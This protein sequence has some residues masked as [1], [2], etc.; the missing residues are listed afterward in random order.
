MSTNGPVSVQGCA[1][2]IGRLAADGSVV[3]SAVGMVQDDRS[4]VKLEAKP[5]MQ[6][7]VEI[8]PISGCGVPV[9]SYKDC[10][11]YKRWDINLTIGDMDFEKMEILG[12][13]AILTAAGSTGRTF[14]DG[15]VTTNLNTLSSPA[16]AAFLPSD[17]GRSVTGT[18]IPS[19]TFISQYVS[20]TLVRI[21]NLATATGAGL[22]IVLGAQPVSTIGYQ[23]PHLLL[24]ACPFGVSIEVWSKAIVRGTGY[25]GFA[26][27][28]SSGTQLVP[29][30]GYFRTG[31]FRSFLWHDAKTI[32]NKEET[33]MFTGWAIENP[34]FGTGP[35]DDW[36]VS[37]LPGAIG[38]ATPIDTTAWCNIMADFQLPGVAANTGNIGPGYQTSPF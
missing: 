19:N 29:G 1:Y 32:E 12:Q 4:F 18:G 20:S 26:Q 33:P 3:A 7:G 35:V 10:D 27:F 15:A 2:R 9:I 24:T 38:A 37:G 25:Q 13:G 5:N 31:I 22:S 21:N 17:V 28:P 34:N 8:T 36:R 6:A 30:S 23:Y 11:R 14:N 16:L